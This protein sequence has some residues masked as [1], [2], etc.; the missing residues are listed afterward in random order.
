M[1]A[2]AKNLDY[3]EVA[4]AKFSSH[5]LIIHL[6]KAPSRKSETRENRKNIIH[7]LSKLNL[8]EQLSNPTSLCDS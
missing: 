6:I 8:G 1:I 7:D 5:L 4:A 2:G 3:V